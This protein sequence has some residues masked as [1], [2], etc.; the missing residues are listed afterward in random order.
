MIQ[1][2]KKTLEKTLTAALAKLAAKD[3]S[4]G[5]LKKCSKCG[6]WYS[7]N[8][9]LEYCQNKGL[10]MEGWREWSCNELFGKL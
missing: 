2:T 5:K 1:L 9:H 10:N 7:Q 4:S 6:K 3:N 8:N